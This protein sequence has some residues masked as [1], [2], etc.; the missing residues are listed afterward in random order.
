MD[1]LLSDNNNL[2]NYKI[3]LLNFCTTLFT[4]LHVM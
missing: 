3:L 4:A 1:K 2:F